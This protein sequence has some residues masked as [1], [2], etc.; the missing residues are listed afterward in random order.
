MSYRGFIT[1]CVAAV[2]I[3]PA[4][5]LA[6]PETQ[7]LRQE[8]ELL[9]KQVQRLEA[10]LEKQETDNVEAVDEEKIQK[11][12]RSTHEEELTKQIDIGGAIRVQLARR[13]QNQND[14]A[15][16]GEIDLD[17][18]RLNFDGEISNILFSGEYRFYSSAR[19]IHHGWF[20]YDFTESWQVRLGIQQVPFGI[21]PFA[22]HNFFFSSNYYLGLEDDYDTGINALYKNGAH[23][24]Q[25]AFFKNDEYSGGNGFDR[26][27][28]DPLNV[29]RVN[30]DGSVDQQSIEEANTVNV[31]YA[32]T[33]GK[34]TSASSQV[35]ISA[36]GGRIYNSTND[37]T[38]E[39]W[40]AATHL[41]GNYGP[42]NLMLQLTRYDINPES[43]DGFDDNIIGTG[44]YGFEYTIP[45]QAWTYL[46]NM[47]RTQQVDIG[48][49]T[50]LTYYND[51]TYI[52]KDDNRFEETIQ[53]VTGVSIA[54]GALFTYV[55]FV[56][57]KNQPF[58]NPYITNGGFGG[59]QLTDL[60]SPGANDWTT[61][62]NIN[63]GY[64]F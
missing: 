15:T 32:Y 26:Y 7:A 3:T 61:R 35:G 20:G 10:R 27:S 2:L 16:V 62:F 29:A 58:T 19:F 54:A 49:I 17:T 59:A 30:A 52:D 34:D 55:D 43:S 41:N 5:A 13:G 12:A 25:L 57:G 18:V 45:A 28:Y 6:N 60:G 33:F 38:G 44:A 31:R 46:F 53:N 51:F 23:D 21:T 37:R 63:F 22:S 56:L 14:R 64:Y 40:A 11:V 47:A 4:V 1:G 42:W 9:K 36:Q 50:A 8:L 48:P 39:Q 24:L